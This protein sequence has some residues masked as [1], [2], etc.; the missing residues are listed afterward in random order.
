IGIANIMIISMLE[1]QSEI[2]LRRALGATRGQIRGQFFAEALL[3]SL[4]GGAAGITFGTL[5]TIA[6]AATKN[7]GVV[8][9][10]SRCPGGRGPP[11]RWEPS[12]DSCRPSAPPGC[13][14]PTHFGPPS[15]TRSTGPW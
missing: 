9:P 12:P 10:P 6:Y 4:L 1:R 8:I 13:H 2:G 5:A 15:R 14:Q 7:W 11:S 3:L